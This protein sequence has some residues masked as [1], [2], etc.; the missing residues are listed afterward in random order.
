MAGKT[1]PYL[2]DTNIPFIVRGPGVPRGKTSRLPGTHL[3]LTPTFLDIACV[4]P[5]N[6]PEFLDG[7]SLLSDWLDPER[8][9]NGSESAS[10]DIINVEFWGRSDIE[11]P[12]LDGSIENSYKTVRIV[13]EE[14]S[15]LYTKWC[16]G[17]TELYETNVCL[18]KMAPRNDVTANKHLLCYS[19]IL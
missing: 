11:V 19:S 8:K 16:T 14:S 13:G 18:R 1:L 3:D 6:F 15:W 9:I 17:D 7:R 2:E 4:D 5:A 10:R 12:G